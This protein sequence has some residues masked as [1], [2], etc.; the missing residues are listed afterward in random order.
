M[1]DLFPFKLKLWEN[2]AL[3]LQAIFGRPDFASIANGFGLRGSNITSLD[4]FASLLRNYEAAG[5]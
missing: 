5:E 2:P 4:Q 3:A 1:A